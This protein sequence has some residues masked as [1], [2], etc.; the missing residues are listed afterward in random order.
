VDQIVDVTKGV[1]DRETSQL[2]C[3]EYGFNEA[4]TLALES[5][6]AD[7]AGCVPNIV[8]TASLSAAERST[9]FAFV[10]KQPRKST[11]SQVGAGPRRKAASSSA[12]LSSL[13]DAEASVGTDLPAGDAGMREAGGGTKQRRYLLFFITLLLSCVPGT[14]T[15][16]GC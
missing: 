11:L 13:V 5:P 12:E 1:V 6:K 14:S 4:V 2:L 3:E 16:P 10:K 8:D 9:P 15:K 7:C